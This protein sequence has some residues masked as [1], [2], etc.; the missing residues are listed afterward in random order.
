M[1]VYLYIYSKTLEYILERE[2]EIDID[3]REIEIDID[4]YF[5]G[6]NDMIATSE[7]DDKDVIVSVCWC[8]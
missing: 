1:F 7:F 2:I 4:S 6:N 5:Y 8:G 3:D